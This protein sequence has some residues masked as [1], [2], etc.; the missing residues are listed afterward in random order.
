MKSI[1]KLTL[2]SA[3]LLGLAA[4]GKHTTGAVRSSGDIV[5]NGAGIYGSVHSGTT[6]FYKLKNIVIGEKYTLR[7]QI[8]LVSDGTV[9]VPDGTLNVTVYKSE[10]AYSNKQPEPIDVNPVSARPNVYEA[11]FSAAFSGDYVV[12]ISGASISTI[13]MQFFY[14]LRVMSSTTALTSFTTATV[15]AFHSQIL[16]VGHLAV[17][18]GALVTPSGAYPITLT[19]NATTTLGYPQMFVYKDDTLT[20]NSLLLSSIPTSTNFRITTFDAGT[21]VGTP[22]LSDSYIIS[23]ATSSTLTFSAQGPYIAV[24]GINS[25]ATYTLTVGP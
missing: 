4:C 22:A 7:T 24:K 2:L 25:S 12:A 1:L 5:V 9:T 16:A 3:L 6:L 14:D 8:A 10:T 20:I 21:E 17:Y 11:H 13:G 23:A 18:N 15:P 19:S